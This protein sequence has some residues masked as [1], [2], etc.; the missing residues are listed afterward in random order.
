[1]APAGPEDQA[2]ARYRHGRLLYRKPLT[3]A[4][5]VGGFRLE[6]DA[7]V[8]FPEG[9]LR[10]ASRRDPAGGQA[11]NF[12]LWCPEEFPDEIAVSW[13]FWPL[14]EPGLCILFFAA[15]GGG[16]EDLFDSRLARRAGEYPQ[17]HSGEI[18]ALHVPDFRRRSRDER[19]FHVC[20]LRK[21]RG[22]D[23]VAQGADP[24]P[25][26]EDARP[27][28][29]PTPTKYG[30]QVAFAINGLPISRWADDGRAYGWVPAGG[31][32]G[33]RQMAPLV[34]GYANCRV[35]ALEAEGGEGG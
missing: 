9:R 3:G 20:N 10:L 5:D 7:D 32:I 31:K 21:S 13:E 17:Y 1:M 18:S 4:A 33:F 28:Y 25:S 29:H 30:P 2:P 15:R 8:T 12:V 23:L 26:V 6:G 22:F 24:L 27:P 14:R 34:A 19:A 16:G 11:A 35:H